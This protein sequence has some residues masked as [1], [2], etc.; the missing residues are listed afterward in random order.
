MFYLCVQ[1]P[2]SPYNL[3]V[4]QMTVNLKV[5]KGKTKKGL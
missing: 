4:L 1:I 5:K 3:T 2:E